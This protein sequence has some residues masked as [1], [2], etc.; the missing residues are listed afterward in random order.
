M[1]GFWLLVVVGSGFEVVMVIRFFFY[2]VLV[3]GEFQREAQDLNLIPPII[4]KY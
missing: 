1:I 4:Y 3:T 2:L